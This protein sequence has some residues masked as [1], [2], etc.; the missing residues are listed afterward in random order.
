MDPFFSSMPVAPPPPIPPPSVIPVVPPF[1][2]NPTTATTVAGGPPPSFDHP[3]YSD[4]ICEAIGAL[5]D[6][7]GSSKRAIA[8]YIESA[9]KD[10]PP[11]HSA[12]LT[13]HLKRLKNNGILVMVKKSYKLASTARSEVPIPDS[14]PSN[15]PDVS[16]PPGFKRSRGRPPKP[17]PTI[18]A[19]AD[20]I[21]QQ[22]QQ[23][24][25]QQPLPAPI[26]DDT[27]RSPGRPR[28]NGPVAPL[29]VRK[30]RG[31]PPKTGPKKSPGRP[32]KPKTVRSVV[33][34][35]A[36]KRGRGRPPKVLNQMP[37]PAVMP[38]QGQPM[39]VPYADTAAAVPTT[40][41]A[42]GPRPRGRPKGTAVA[43]AGLAVPGKGRGRPPKSGGVAA[44]PIKPKKSTGK[45]V[46]RPKKT[47]DGAA[48]YGDLKRKLEFFQSKVKQAVGVLKSQFSSESNISAIDAI[49]E[50]EVLAAMD[51]NKPFKDDAQP[52]PPPPPAP[53][54]TQP[55]PMPQNMEG[56]VY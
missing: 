26:P 7:N 15:P 2:S 24:Q 33:G 56:Q 16:S 49:Q 53:E 23:Q 20:P 47:T 35:N 46:G 50:L 45:P 36:M 32:R 3:S 30:G 14:T 52:P 25:Q 38:I 4:M 34:A 42:A 37:Q 41:V 40:A 28:K 13:H 12:L 54:P 5:K 43:P 11:T 8:K 48:S 51:I 39:A 31:R 21:P 22:Q 10:L 6:K 29:G 44:K 18:S 17:K 27:K 9:H 1:V 55:A 19:P